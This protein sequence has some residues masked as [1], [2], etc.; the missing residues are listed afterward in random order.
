LLKY[1]GHNDIPAHCHSPPMVNTVR[2]QQ[3]C[4]WHA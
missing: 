2:S 3:S 1:F 4:Q